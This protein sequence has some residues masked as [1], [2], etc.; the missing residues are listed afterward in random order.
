MQDHNGI[1]QHGLETEGRRKKHFGHGG[2]W[3]VLGKGKVR[4]GEAA[5]GGLV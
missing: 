5:Q 2:Y 1:H 3:G 4:Q